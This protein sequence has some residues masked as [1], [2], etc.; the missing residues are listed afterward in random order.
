M[1]FTF[2]H[3]KIVPNFRSSDGASGRETACQWR[4][5][6]RHRYNP[7]FGKTPWSRKWHSTPVFLPG[8]FH[9]QRSLVGHSALGRKESDMTERAHKHACVHG[10]AFHIVAM[11]HISCCRNRVPEEHL[12]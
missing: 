5:C 3:K 6:K 9:R 4:R 1:Y 11:P 12:C 10:D 7:W 2:T 8:K